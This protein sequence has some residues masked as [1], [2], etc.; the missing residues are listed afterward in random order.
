[1]NVITCTRTDH[2]H[3]VRLKHSGYNYSN[4]PHGSQSLQLFF[5]RYR[6]D[7]SVWKHI[8]LWVLAKIPWGLVRRA[9]HFRSKIARHVKRNDCGRTQIDQTPVLASTTLI[10]PT[11]TELCCFHL[12]DPSFAMMPIKVQFELD[13]EL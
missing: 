1:M 5:W 4:W 11:P 12:V 7:V 8:C 6:I 10:Y 3:M 2:L 13:Q 9:A